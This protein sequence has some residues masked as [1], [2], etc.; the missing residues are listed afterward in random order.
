[1]IGHF[2]EFQIFFGGKSSSPMQSNHDSPTLIIGAGPA[3]LA[4]AGRLSGMGLPFQLLEKSDRVAASWHA[5]YDRL[6][7]HTVK[8]HSDLPLMPMP[9][10]FPLYVPRKDMIAY[11][12]KY[13]R[14]MNIAPLFGQEVRKII[15]EGTEWR[16]ETG[17]NVFHAPNV[18]VATGYNRVPVVPVWEGREHFKGTFMHSREYRNAASFSGKKVLIVGIGNTGAE[19][20]LDLHE[21][22]AF[23]FISVR[24]PVN[25]ICRDIGGRP[26]Q[27]TAILLGKLPDWAYDFIAR[28]VQRLTVGDLSAYGLKTPHYSP[29]E[30]LRRYGKVPVIDIG[31]LDLIKQRKVRILPDIQRFNADSV[32]FINGETEPFDAVI[33]CT[34][35]RA[36]VE[37]FIEN[38]KP[39]L[40]QRGYPKQLWFE[41]EAYKGLY[42]CGFSIPLSGILRNIKMDSAEIVAHIKNP[43]Y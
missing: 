10:A 27:R 2:P 1:M 22:G 40:D 36:Q 28:Q 30:G 15:R 18:V 4:V 11:W 20:A 42:F 29:S 23:P 9:E 32:T 21:H 24:N 26:A 19:L 6:R 31:T 3:G 8:E 5:H 12:E 7:L 41:D 38:A 13:V 14:D 39:L 43:G 17:K 34:G 37:D 16:V 35:Y 33:A 25:F